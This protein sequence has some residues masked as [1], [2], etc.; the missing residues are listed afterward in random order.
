MVVPTG[1]EPV[2]YHLGENQSNPYMSNFTMFFK[3]QKRCACKFVCKILLTLL[4]FP[5]M[6]GFGQLNNGG[7]VTYGKTF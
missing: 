5:Y 6:I 2:A 7:F 1:V 4:N 3:T